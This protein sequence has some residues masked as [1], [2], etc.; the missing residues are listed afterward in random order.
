VQPPARV[1]GVVFDLDGTL[2]DTLDDIR[3]TLDRALVAGGFPERTRE[4]IARA[5]GDGAKNLVARAMGVSSDDARVD[6]MLARY[7]V[8]YEADP[9]PATRAMPGALELLDALRACGVR[10]AICTNKPRVV[11]DRVLA[12]ALPSAFDAVVAGGDVVRLKPEPDPILAALDKMDVA[13]SDAV[14]IGDGAQDVIAAR[15][16]RV[17]S[18]GCAFGYGGEKLRAAKP[19]ATVDSLAEVATILRLRAR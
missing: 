13:P 12:R 5:V 8:E 16:A 10:V 19:D 9:T 17:F 2:L 1:R 6:P 14:M 4:E 3:I 18:I 7:L 15:A 11:A